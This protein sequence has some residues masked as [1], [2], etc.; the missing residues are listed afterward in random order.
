MPVNKMK[1]EIKAKWVAALRSGEYAQ[2][3]CCLMQNTSTGPMFCCL[4]VLCDL[5]VKA[6]AEVTWECSNFNGFEIWYAAASTNCHDKHSEML[7]ACVQQW[8]G[9]NNVDPT[10]HLSQFARKPIT[11]VNDRERYS[12]SRIADLIEAQL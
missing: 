3:T 6:G 4:G 9:L 12:F 5:A 1:P 7:P 2:G 8:A 10:V 11:Q